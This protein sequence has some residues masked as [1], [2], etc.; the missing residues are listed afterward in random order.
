VKNKIRIAVAFGVFA[1][2]EIANNILNYV[3]E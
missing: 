3:K 2:A 1:A